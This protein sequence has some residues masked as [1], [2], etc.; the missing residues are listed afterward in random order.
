MLLYKDWLNILLS[1]YI[2]RLVLELTICVFKVRESS[3]SVQQHRVKVKRSSRLALR[4]KR[5]QVGL[6][7]ADRYQGLPV[8]AVLV[9]A[10]IRSTLYAGICSG[11]GLLFAREHNFIDFIEK[12]IIYLITSNNFAMIVMLDFYFFLQ[13]QNFLIKNFF[14]SKI[15]LN[16]ILL[17]YILS[18][19]EILI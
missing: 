15:T 17:L 19:T 11:H 3:R 18:I 2:K 5:A 16:Q 4:R 9:D 6:L 8:G 1:I 13:N 7:L 14:L 10:E 12:K